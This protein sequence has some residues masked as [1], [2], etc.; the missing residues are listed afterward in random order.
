MTVPVYAMD[1]IATDMSAASNASPS[2][3]TRRARKNAGTA[4]S[5]IMSAFTVFTPAYASGRL[6]K[7]A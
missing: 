4:A 2:R 7:S 3:T 5:D 1:G 6:S